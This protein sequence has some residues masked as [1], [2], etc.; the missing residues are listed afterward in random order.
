MPEYQFVDHPDNISQNITGHEQLGVDTEFMREKTYFAQLCLVQ[1]ALPGTDD[2]DAVLVD[3][4]AEDMSCL[5]YTSPS[6]RDRG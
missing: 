4:L 3:P 6:P 2:S 5:L 1:L